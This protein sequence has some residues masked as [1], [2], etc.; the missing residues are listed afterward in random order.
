MNEKGIKVKFQKFNKAWI[1]LHK[2]KPA[3]ISTMVTY[4]LYFKLVGL[5]FPSG[6]VH[7]I[8]G[9]PDGWLTWE[10]PSQVRR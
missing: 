4:L 1:Q 9:D 10:F 8:L 6:T 7:D 5:V 2:R 3:A